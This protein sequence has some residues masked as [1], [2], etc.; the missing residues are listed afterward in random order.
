METGE[1]CLD[2]SVVIPVYN[3]AGN[4]EQLITDVTRV[5]GAMERSYEIL[6][7]DDGSDDGSYEILLR[8]RELVPYLRIIRLR[9]NFGQT[10]ALAAGFDYAR[11]EVIVTMDADLQNDPADI[12]GLI[13]ALADEDADVVAGWRWKRRDPLLTRR[14]PSR[15]AN[16]V[17]SRVTNV[18]LHDYG[19]TLRVYR[20][21][22]AKQ[23]RL[24]GELHRFIPALAV[25]LG[26]KVT[27]RRVGHRARISGES[28]YGLSRTIRVML[29]LVTVK[30]LAGYSTRPIQ[31][32][33]LLG[34]VSTAIGVLWTGYL[35]FER[36]VLQRPLANRPVLLLTIL[37]TVIGVQ[38]I[39]LGLIGE[40]LART[41][42]ESQ[43]KPIYSVRDVA[44]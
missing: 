43:A 9:R 8:L 40:M 12:P 38:F 44:E 27:E 19:C 29:D 7:V 4:L 1:P 42:H 20:R 39:S 31:V 35:G 18:R 6:T 24:Y 16:W 14:L 26:G 11:G 23:V 36:L 37:L 13:K 3:E 2:V 17:I 33:G 5:L 34:V 25:D 30:F 32:F 15:I 10:A 22:L 28:K 41:Y 21:E